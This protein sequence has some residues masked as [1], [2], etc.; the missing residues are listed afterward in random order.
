M[1]KSGSPTWFETRT[2]RTEPRF[3]VRDGSV[4]CLSENLVDLVEKDSVK[5]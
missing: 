2:A 1:L 4:L 3:E 5:D